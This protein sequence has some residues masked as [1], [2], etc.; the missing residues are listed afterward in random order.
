MFFLVLVL[1]NDNK[2]NVCYSGT[3]EMENVEGNSITKH[4]W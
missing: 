4:Q 2:P 3:S 1:L